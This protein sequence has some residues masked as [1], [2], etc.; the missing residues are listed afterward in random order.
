MACDVLLLAAFHPELAP[1]RGVL[2]EGLR[3][4]VGGQN[5]VAG[6]V[7]I[8]AT[9]AA[10]G[11]AMQLARESPRLVVALGS[12]G[13][14]A[15]AGLG[16]G[17]VVVSRRVRLASG[18]AADRLAQFPE[19]MSIVAD[20]HPGLVDSLARA[21]AK[22][23]DVAATLAITTDDA[24]AARLSAH[25]GAA[26]EHLEAHGVAVACAAVGVAFAAVLGVANMV[27]SSARDEWRL[28]H[29]EAAAATADVLVRWLH[30]G[31]IGMGAGG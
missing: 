14:Y 31:G 26:V 22:P 12:C 11:A 24:A 16:I 23:V 7:G 17:E 5:I 18:W 4:R 2:G 19:P 28:H 29:R 1:L 13:A 27:G 6:V 10:A 8:G 21:G 20:S 3:A 25:T 15:G 30:A 9:L